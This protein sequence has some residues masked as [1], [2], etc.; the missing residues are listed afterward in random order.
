MWSG[1]WSHSKARSLESRTIHISF[2]Q[3]RETLLNS[4][5]IQERVGRSQASLIQ[6][7]RQKTYQ[8][9][10]F[11]GSPWGDL[12]HQC[13][14]K[15]AGWRWGGVQEYWEVQRQFSSIYP[16]WWWEMPLDRVSLT[17]VGTTDTKIIDEGAAP[18]HQKSGALS[19]SVRFGSEPKG[20]TGRK[21]WKYL[22][23]YGFP[24]G[25]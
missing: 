25:K 7:I 1:S 5:G 18:S 22:I 16:W 14:R 15:C 21:L 12:S 8:T 20:Q 10:V 19:R 23:Q 4:W 2:S 17:A 3:S 13:S 6:D 24:R 9:T 11:P